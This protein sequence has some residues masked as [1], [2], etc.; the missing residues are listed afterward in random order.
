VLRLR[1]DNASLVSALGDLNTGCVSLEK[2]NA[3]LRANSE[4]Q[5]KLLAEYGAT[6]ERLRAELKTMTCMWRALVEHAPL[7]HSDIKALRVEVAA[8][9]EEAAAVRER[10]A[11]AVGLLV[12]MPIACSSLGG[13]LPC[14]C[15]RCRRD[16]FLAELAPPVEPGPYKRCQHGRS[17]RFCGGT[18]EISSPAVK[19][20]LPMSTLES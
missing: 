3:R 4:A 13:A 12:Q 18:D 17:D 1:A 19:E 20:K 8:L 9:R 5:L 11:R 16:A 10:L 7:L 2:E 15:W 14:R 6:I